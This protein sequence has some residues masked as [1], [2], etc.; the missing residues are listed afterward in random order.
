MKKSLTL[1]VALM[2]LGLMGQAQ[3][4]IDWSTESIEEPTELRSTS[5]GTAIPVFAVLKN[6]G[7][8][9]VKA[10]DS[11]FRQVLV[12]Q[13][14]NRL[15]LGYPSNNPNQF[16]IQEM[17]RSVAPGDTIHMLIPAL[18]TTAILT[19]SADIKLR[20]TTLMINRGT[21]DPI[22][23]EGQ[24]GLANN[25]AERNMV[26]FNQQGWG[27]SVEEV[28]L[29]DIIKISPNP[30]TTEVNLTWLIGTPASVKAKVQIFDLSGKLVMDETMNGIGTESIDVSA[31]EQGI[32]MV[33]VTN[34]DFT[35]TKK[36]HIA[37]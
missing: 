12:L 2:T 31:L 35:T 25:L 6:N 1:L 17:Q 37:N 19:S 34:G 27:V 10:G 4:Q 30:A 5:T 13:T 9:T 16:N 33:K 7:T 36:L 24:A 11:L 14:N 18:R 20:V 22:A 15:I 21:S 26:W 29:D 23:V 3:R 28:A 8:D 32:Y